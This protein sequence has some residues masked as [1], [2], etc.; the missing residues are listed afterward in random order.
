MVIQ[1]C[2][3]NTAW[4]CNY[5]LKIHIYILLQLESFIRKQSRNL[6]P[7]LGKKIGEF[8]PPNRLP[9]QPNYLL[10]NPRSCS[11]NHKRKI[12]QFATSFIIQMLIPIQFQPTSS[13]L[14]L[15]DILLNNIFPRTWSFMSLLLF[16]NSTRSAHLMFWG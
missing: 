16:S 9:D 7:T 5:N 11:L 8:V 2:I 12:S 1:K 13:L 3:N 14:L 6:T 10:Q 4:K 15:M